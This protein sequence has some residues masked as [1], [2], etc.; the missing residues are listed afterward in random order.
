[1]KE[2][3]LG[4]ITAIHGDMNTKDEQNTFVQHD[5]KR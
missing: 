2:L 5:A 4:S 1:M 3:Q